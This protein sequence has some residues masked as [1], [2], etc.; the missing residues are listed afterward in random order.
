[1][2]IARCIILFLLLLSSKTAFPG[3]F[4]SDGSSVQECME[5]RRSDIKNDNQQ[6][7]AAQ[8]CRSKFP[9]PAY[10]YETAN[11]YDVLAAGSNNSRFQNWTS[12]ITWNDTSI[13]HYGKD[14]G[15]GVKSNDFRY[16][17]EIVATNRN[18][19]PIAGLIIGISKKKGKC[20]WDDKDYA[21]IY[22]CT[23]SASPKQTGTFNCDIPNV[24]KKKSYYCLAGFQVSA[25]D[26]RFKE[27]I[28]GQ[29]PVPIKD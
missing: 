11:I 9:A 2:K 26:S 24:E 13:K 29:P 16:Y 12:N 8:Y 22:T 17:L 27:V 3:W 15:Y 10:I 21:E 18:E 28:L 4:T 1:M 20:S 19:I 7:I 6:K 25:T 5:N 23:G 14:Y